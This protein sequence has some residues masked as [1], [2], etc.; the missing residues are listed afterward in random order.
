MY[1]LTIVKM[2]FIAFVSKEPNVQTASEINRLIILVSSLILLQ[3]SNL[4]RFSWF[5]LWKISSE[6]VKVGK[7]EEGSFLSLLP[8]H[9][10]APIFDSLLIILFRVVH[11]I[12]ADLVFRA[13]SGIVQIFLR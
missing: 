1:N 8:V 11:V 5:S 13:D 9:F 12:H 3:I 7:G 2:N 4:L 6:R 10:I